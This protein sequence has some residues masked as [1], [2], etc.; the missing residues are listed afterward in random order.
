MFEIKIRSKIW[1]K[2]IELLLNTY[3]KH[4]K[5]SRLIIKY[6]DLIQNTQKVLKE[7]YRF[8]KIQISKENLDRLTKKYMFENIPFEMKGSG[9]VTRFAKPGKWNESFNEEEKQVMNNIMK[10][11]LL[12]IG[13]K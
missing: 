8:L 2:T 9:K 10:D 3:E 6:E 5:D 4:N 12:K 1:V 7:I 11:T 13:Y